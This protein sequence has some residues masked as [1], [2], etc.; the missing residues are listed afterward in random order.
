MNLSW[1]PTVDYVDF[2]THVSTALQ[3][4]IEALAEATD[5]AR[6]QLLSLT[7][8]LDDS[9]WKKFCAL[10]EKKPVKFWTC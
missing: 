2:V 9:F 7:L 10:S 5:S 4:D 6:K 8:G 3:N 1:K